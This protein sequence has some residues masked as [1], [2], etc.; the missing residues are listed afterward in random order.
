[1]S[2]ESFSHVTT[3][4]FD[5]DNTLY[6]PSVRLF[7]QIETRMTAYV[8]NALGVS[9][10]DADHMRAHYWQQYGTTLAGLMR[11]HDIDPDPYLIDV[12]DI[13]FAEL[14]PD[15]QLATNIRNLPGRC[16]VYTN[17]TAPYAEK[18]L[19]GRKLTGLFDAIYGIEHAN[20]LPKPENAAFEIIFTKDGLHTQTAAMFE[21]DARNLRAPHEMGMQTVHVSPTE[22]AASH[23]HHHTSDL[24][25]FLS[26]LY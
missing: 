18:V 6:P 12:H 17:G 13:S 20:Y 11:E 19:E 21:D 8:M 9:R 10:S 26:R 7:D 14:E 2:K 4:V 23:I 1:M 16:I 5:L 24:T 22:Q 3:W 25:D 15:H